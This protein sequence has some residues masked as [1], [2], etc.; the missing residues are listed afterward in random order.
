MSRGEIEQILSSLGDFVQIDHLLRFIK[1]PGVSSEMKKFVY[2]K[3]A[4][5]YE[6]KGMFFD[7]SKSYNNAAI[8][9]LNDLE[10]GNY[11]LK[12]CEML[13]KGGF[14][15]N[16]DKALQSV[17]TNKSSFEK[18]QIYQKIKELYQKQAEFYESQLKR[19]N[20]VRVYEKMLELRLEEKEKAEIKKRLVELYE[21]L[22]KKKEYM[23]AG[24]GGQR[25]KTPWIKG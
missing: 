13:I 15:D 23:L 2:V 14:F 9:C 5:I 16:I 21:K 25:R 6:R 20:A 10:K 17:Y 22:G 4:S 18:A 11:Y 3:L 7:A 19:S 8:H 1:E 12:E 24:Q